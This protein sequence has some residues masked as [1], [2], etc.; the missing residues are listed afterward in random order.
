MMG[1]VFQ[2]ASS[3][4]DWVVYIIIGENGGEDVYKNIESSHKRIQA[5]RLALAQK[6]A[7]IMVLDEAGFIKTFDARSGARRH[8]MDLHFIDDC[9]PE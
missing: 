1:E 5:D 7:N 2:E 9:K 3:T 6:Y 4:Y 8:D